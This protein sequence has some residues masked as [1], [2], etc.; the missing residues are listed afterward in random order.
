M[1]TRLIQ[2]SFAALSELGRERE[3]SALPPN[4]AELS[5]CLKPQKYGHRIPVMKLLEKV[6]V[7]S[8]SWDREDWVCPTKLQAP[9]SR[10]ALLQ[11][12]EGERGISRGQLT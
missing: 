2:H 12:M 1:E 7:S 9:Q 8:Q 5:Q 11:E 10:A 4:P 3:L 6:A